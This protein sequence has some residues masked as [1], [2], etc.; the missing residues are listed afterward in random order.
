MPF[1]IP[2]YY[3]ETIGP[4]ELQNKLFSIDLLDI[5]KLPRYL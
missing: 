3:K 1:L 4:G 5:F 2:E